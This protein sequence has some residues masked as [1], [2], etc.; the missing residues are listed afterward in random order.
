MRVRPCGHP[1]AHPS[2]AATISSI[3]TLLTPA[4]SAMPMCSNAADGLAGTV[5][6]AR[7]RIGRGSVTRSIVRGIFPQRASLP[8]STPGCRT[9]QRS[10]G[11]S[12]NH[13]PILPSDVPVGWHQLCV[14]RIRNPALGHL[15]SPV[16]LTTRHPRAG[17]KL[18]VVI[19]HWRTGTG[20]GT[21]VIKQQLIQVQDRVDPQW[22]QWQS[23]N[24]RH[25]AGADQ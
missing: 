19:D 22:T 8:I 12:H 11:D 15:S 23:G 2:T 10:W 5:R 6:H 18:W 25:H 17:E 20:T 4:H 7:R 16:N 21:C 1:R 3:S 9:H 24:A 14:P 13:E